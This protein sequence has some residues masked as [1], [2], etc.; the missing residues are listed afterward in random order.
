MSRAAYAA[1]ALLLL[2][3]GGCSRAIILGTRSADGGER[4]DGSQPGDGSAPLD[5]GPCDG[6]CIDLAKPSLIVDL[7]QPIDAADGSTD[8]LATPVDLAAPPDL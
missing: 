3:A 8:D 1:L 5:A 7:A 4:F 2:V 6:P